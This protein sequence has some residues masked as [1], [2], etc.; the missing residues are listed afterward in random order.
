MP[1]T[2]EYAQGFFTAV[3][4]A[5]AVSDG[6]GNKAFALLMSYK[7]P[8]EPLVFGLAVLAGRGVRAGETEP[9]IFHAIDKGTRRLGASL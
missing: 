1:D 3:L 8:H 5:K 7:G 6:D 2:D 9:E 4:A